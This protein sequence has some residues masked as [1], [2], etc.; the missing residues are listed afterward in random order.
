MDTITLK[1]GEEIPSPLVSTT[2]MA[3]QHLFYND[4]G[5]FCELVFTCRDPQHILW[6]G[7]GKKLVRLAMLE[8]V[9]GSGHGHA[10]DAIKS[11]VLSAV[12]GED[13]E[14]RLVSPVAR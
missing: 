1:N 8:S 14:M 9:D 2:M 4:P 13:F 12:E 10:H 7:S 3:L 11:I 6:R 5:T